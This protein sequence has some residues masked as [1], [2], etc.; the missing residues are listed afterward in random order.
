[1]G[2]NS[3]TLDRATEPVFTT[4]PAGQGTGLGLSQVC[5]FA[6]QAGGSLRI[7]S[8]PGKGISVTILLERRQ[9]ET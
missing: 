9:G 8:P 7:E 1:M 3:Q 4:K 6:N 2:M 5:G